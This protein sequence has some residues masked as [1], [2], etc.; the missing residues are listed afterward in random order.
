MK[1]TITSDV[2][3]KINFLCQIFLHLNIAMEV[4]FFKS[5]FR[6]KRGGRCG[7]LMVSALVSGLSGPG[8][9][10]GREHCPNNLV[11]RLMNFLVVN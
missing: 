7:G 9:S 3:F 6:S 11:P 8:S 5:V 1:T 4:P 10:P 2:K